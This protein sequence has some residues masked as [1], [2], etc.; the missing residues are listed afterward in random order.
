MPLHRS[1]VERPYQQFDDA[2]DLYNDKFAKPVKA[3]MDDLT[4]A[5]K[6]TPA[7]FDERIEWIW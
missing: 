2:V 7:P 1:I 5:G 6:I 3:I 4:K